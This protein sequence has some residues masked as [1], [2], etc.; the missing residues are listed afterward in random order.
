[1]LPRDQPLPA[2]RALFVLV[3]DEPPHA[4]T[5]VACEHAGATTEATRV[6]HAMA[7]A[8]I[9][10]GAKSLG[11]APSLEDLVVAVHAGGRGRGFL[12]VVAGPDGGVVNADVWS[13]EGTPAA[14]LLTLQVMLAEAR[15]RWGIE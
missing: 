2:G 7:K 5:A 10:G 9:A 13:E 3:V 4:F 8:A 11:C 6:V 14:T 1:M 12:L 15:A